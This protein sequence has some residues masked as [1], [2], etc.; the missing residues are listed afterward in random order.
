MSQYDESCPNFPAKINELR[1]VHLTVQ[2]RPQSA[3]EKATGREKVGDWM[4]EIIHYEACTESM[5]RVHHK[6]S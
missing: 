6:S 3:D 2:Y 1:N 4:Q 5:L